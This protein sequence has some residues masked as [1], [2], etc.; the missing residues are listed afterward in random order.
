MSVHGHTCQTTYLDLR[1]A[2]LANHVQYE[3]WNTSESRGLGS[4]IVIC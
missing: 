2:E 3:D 1:A 4:W